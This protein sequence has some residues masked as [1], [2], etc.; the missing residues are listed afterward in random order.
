[1]PDADGVRLDAIAVLVTERATANKNSTWPYVGLE[2][3]PS[4]GSRLL[5]FAQ[6]NESSST[7]N[8]FHKGD[9]LFGKLRPRLRKSVQAALDGYCS[10]DILVLRPRPDVDSQFA[11]YVFQSDPVFSEAIRLEEGTRM[12]RCSWSKLRELRVFCPELSHQ[13]RIAEVLSSVDNA[14]EG[15]EALVAKTRQ[16]KLGLSQDLFARG[17]TPEGRLRP[18]P[19]EARHLYKESALGPIPRDWDVRDLRNC[20]LANPT[21]GIYK[22]AEDIGSGTLLVGQTS[23]TEERWV[24]YSL[25][26][27]AVVTGAEQ[28]QYSLEEND[29]VLSRVF[30]TLEGVG[31]PALV[32]EPPEPAVYESNM[33]RLRVDLSVIRPELLFEWLMTDRARRLIIAGA[34]ASNQTSI[35][36]QVLSR[37]PVPIPPTNEQE[38]I[39]GVIQALDSR[40]MSE[41][42][43][44]AKQRSLKTALLQDLMTDRVHAASP[45]ALEGVRD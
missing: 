28:A 27:R 40:A 8:I 45:T 43:G 5:G 1:M 29:I 31:R 33:M 11:G 14:I 44:L 24:D 18:T 23:F 7:N 10:T 19:G 26:R 34:N 6:S 30:A 4:G 16:I 17:I 39:V 3:V 2:H 22:P 25:A 15:F 21:N 35:N 32:P 41:R 12:P 42:E 38:Q 36:Q 37:L 20:L 13:R 9:I